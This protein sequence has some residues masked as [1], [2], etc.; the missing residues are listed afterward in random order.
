MTKDFR[1]IWETVFGRQH[2]ARSV[3]SVSAHQWLR[4]RHALDPHCDYCGVESVLLRGSCADVGVVK[5]RA[6]LDHIQPLSRGGKRGDED[7]FALACHSCNQRK[8][9]Q[10]PEVF[11]HCGSRLATEILTSM[12][13]RGQYTP[14][15]FRD[16]LKQRGLPHGTLFMN[17]IWN[18]ATSN[19]TVQLGKAFRQPHNQRGGL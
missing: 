6:T 13:A 15:W 18:R 12:L 3:D 5:N 8:G 10:H 11:M 9:N 17:L 2:R 1:G 19:R 7:N 4:A 14:E 16:A